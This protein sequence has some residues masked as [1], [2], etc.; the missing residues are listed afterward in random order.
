MLAF[1]GYVCKS[2]VAFLTVKVMMCF[3]INCLSK[4]DILAWFYESCDGFFSCKSDDVFSI[5]SKC[6]DDVFCLAMIA[7]V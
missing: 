1:Q 3:F 6:D 4:N 5:T 2:Y 7:R